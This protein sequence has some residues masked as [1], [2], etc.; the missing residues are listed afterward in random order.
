MACI[1][2]VCGL[3]SINGIDAALAA[4]ADMVGF[5][6]FR[7]SPRSISID[8]ASDLSARVPD[9]VVR[10]GL[11]VD[12]DDELL[13]SIIKNVGVDMMQFHGKESPERIKE[14]RHRFNIP[15]IKA[16]AISGPRDVLDS[17]K[18]AKAADQLL[19]DA[20]APKY[21]TRPGGNAKAFDWPLI[22]NKDWGLPWILAGGLTP[23]NVAEAIVASG[24]RSVDVSSGV[25]DGNGNKDA[26]KI[27][28]FIDAAKSVN[29]K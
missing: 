17:E 4:G 22:A 5:V 27:F 12:A 29:R 8:V 26:Q 3:K 7:P 10:V 28:A 20:K 24:A 16:M 6:F 14:V 25:E 19:F 13:E 23:E 9:N 18:Y 2:K 11:S 21:A 1:V 15:I